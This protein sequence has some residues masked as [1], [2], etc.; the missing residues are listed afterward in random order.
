MTTLLYT[1][2]GA[3]HLKFLNLST[4]DLVNASNS[5]DMGRRCQAVNC[6]S[7]FDL[8]QDEIASQAEGTVPEPREY[9]VRSFPADVER[10]KK[11]TSALRRHD[12]V[13]IK[14]GGVCDK[15]FKSDDFSQTSVVKTGL[16]RK[17]KRLKPNAVP[18]LWPDY[19]TYFAEVTE[20]RPRPPAASSSVRLE[21][22]VRKMTAL[23]Q[24][25]LRSDIIAD[26]ANLVNKLFPD[27]ANMRPSILQHDF[28]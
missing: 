3:K 8:T 12:T 25:F 15:H 21:R 6:R 13:D 16:E 26:Y 20:P 9:S 28:Q 17:H 27:A 10:R 23:E 24:E 18:S 19:P 1:H 22:E 14:N 4:L 5:D 11:W 2:G 7:G